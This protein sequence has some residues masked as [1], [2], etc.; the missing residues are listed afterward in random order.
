MG[1]LARAACSAAP[2]SQVGMAL[3][4]VATLLLLGGVTHMCHAFSHSCI[5]WHTAPITVEKGNQTHWLKHL[6]MISL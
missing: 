5:F 4:A 2:V 6:A 1:C 3:R